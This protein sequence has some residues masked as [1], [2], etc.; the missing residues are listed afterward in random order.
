[1]SKWTRNVAVKTL[2][3]GNPETIQLPRN[4]CHRHL[5]LRLRGTVDVVAGTSAMTASVQG[6]SNILSN[7]RVRRDGK[8]Q[9]FGLSGALLYHLNRIL[10]GQAPVA[11]TP[12]VTNATNTNAS[13]TLIVPFENVRGVKPFDTLLKGA[14]LSSLDLLIDTSTAQSMMLGGNG[15]VTVNNSFTLEVD[16]VEEVG[17]NN[18]AFGDI[19]CYLAQKVG[20]S[21]A[22]SAFQIKPLPVGNRYKGFLIFAEDNGTMLGSDALITNI[23]LKSG[24][25]VFVDRPAQALKDELRQLFNIGASDTGVYYLDLMADGMLNQCLDVTPE[26]GNETLELELVTTA[27]AGT[28]NIY[29]VALE[30]VQPVVVKK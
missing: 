6:A 22:S 18:Y 21:G 27:P 2:S 3:L 8:E 12:A 25:Q 10:Y 19:R 13:V 20:V 28:A 14:G 26:S 11:T 15:T 7:I 23:K 5:V 29:V 30:Y 9:V 16:T 4:Y 1:M 24:S 17:A